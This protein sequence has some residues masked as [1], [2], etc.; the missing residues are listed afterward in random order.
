MPVKALVFD[1]FGTVVDWRTSIIEQF[2]AFG[3]EKGI[4]VN[5]AAWGLGP[6]THTAQGYELDVSTMDTFAPLWTSSTTMPLRVRNLRNRGIVARISTS[7]TMK[8]R[9]RRSAETAASKLGGSLC[10]S[11]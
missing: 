3:R 7:G 11:T 9:A 4:T 5:W 10:F 1:V 2:Q 8:E 6:G